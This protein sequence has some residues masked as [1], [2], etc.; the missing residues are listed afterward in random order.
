MSSLD[1]SEAITF[2]EKKK[3][4]DMEFLSEQI[5]GLNNLEKSK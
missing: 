5:D 4:E 2:V 3:E 1:I